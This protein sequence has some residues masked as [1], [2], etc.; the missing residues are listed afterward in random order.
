[1]SS[2]FRAALAALG[3]LV[4]VSCAAGG[5]V[6]TVNW[7]HPYPPS[8]ARSF[9]AWAGSGGPLLVELRNNPY[10]DPPQQVASIIAEAATAS[11]V[12]PGARFT[13]NPNEAWH[14]DWRM[15]FAFKPAGGD[16]YALIVFCNDWRPITAAGAWS[17]PLVGPN[18]SDFRDFVAQSML[19]LLP[20]ESNGADVFDQMRFRLP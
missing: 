6:R 2:L 14:P 12:L 9:A 18:S 4:L 11:Y 20:N 19:A 3:A 15:V 13:A 1:M 8:T 17:V 10:P 16:W 5:K 7:G